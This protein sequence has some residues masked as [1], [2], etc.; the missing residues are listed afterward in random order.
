MSTAKSPRHRYLVAF[1]LLLP[2]L[3]LGTW[4][5]GRYFVAPGS[6]LAAGAMALGY[7]LLGA[8]L[9]PLVWLA[10]ARYLSA[11]QVWFTAWASGFVTLAL[12]LVAAY[13]VYRGN[14]ESASELAAMHA[15]L[16]A[17]ELSLE[18]FGAD[19]RGSLDAVA[20]RDGVLEAKRGDSVCVGTLAGEE[21]VRLLT[22]IRNVE[23]LAAS[24]VAACSGTG[25]RLTW[26]VE[27]ALPPPTTGA[28]AIDA[29]C[30]DGQ[31]AAAELF[32]VLRR[33][34]EAHGCG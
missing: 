27:E 29:T 15:R 5:G 19:G 4:L 3:F 30:L 26:R 18:P 13:G 9:L 34:L 33:L 20:Y 31:S 17:F 10:L 11:R 6:G 23:M 28:M 1:L 24:D 14:V 16:P 22:S 12:A 7:G 21:R 25:D 8:L 2:G 32:E